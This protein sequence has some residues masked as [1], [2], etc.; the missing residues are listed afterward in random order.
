MTAKYTPSLAPSFGFE[1]GVLP[2]SEVV[3][4][5]AR[6]IFPVKAARNLAARTRASHR[7]AEAWLGGQTGM[8]ADALADLL[9]SDQGLAFLDA[10]MSAG[11]S[12]PSWWESKRA[13]IRATQIERRLD[14]LRVEIEEA[15]RGLR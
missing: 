5:V 3:A 10:I 6:R 4:D 12:A 7:A 14:D 8:S 2:V 1:R 11:A 15:K 9:R 13:D